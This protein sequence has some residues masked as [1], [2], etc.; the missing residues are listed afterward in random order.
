MPKNYGLQVFRISSDIEVFFLGE[1][2]TSTWVATDSLPLSLPLLSPINQTQHRHP[3]QQERRN[4]LSSA[5]LHISLPGHIWHILCQSTG[6]SRLSVYTRA[7]SD[8]TPVLELLQKPTAQWLRLA[9]RLS[10]VPRYWSRTHNRWLSVIHR[11]SQPSDVESETE[12]R[13][14]TNASSHSITKTHSSCAIVVAVSSASAASAA[15]VDNKK[16]RV[17]RKRC[18]E[19]CGIKT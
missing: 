3:C 12:G 4:H 10:R 15:S 14:R 17:I 16:T 18:K 2:V 6:S 7:V 9:T 8:R 13:Q 19:M 1:G 5:S 11:T